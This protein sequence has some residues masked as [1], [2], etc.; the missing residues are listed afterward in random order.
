MPMVPIVPDLIAD[1]HRQWQSYN[2]FTFEFKDYIEDGI[3]PHIDDDQFAEAMK[4]V[5]PINYQDEMADIP[6][7]VIISSDD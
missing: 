1:I 6:T 3:I 7:Y 2:G 5:D 4:I